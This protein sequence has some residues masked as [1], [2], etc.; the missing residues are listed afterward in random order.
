MNKH[1][2]PANLGFDDLHQG[3]RFFLDPPGDR[4]DAA[5]RVTVVEP[6]T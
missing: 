1:R 2:S 5:V 6:L 3:D 4:I